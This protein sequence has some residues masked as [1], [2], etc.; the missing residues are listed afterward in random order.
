LATRILDAVISPMVMRALMGE[1]RADLR[2]NIA[3]HVRQTVAL[4]VEAGT[5]DEFL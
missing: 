5:F 1:N 3:S 2:K 4:F